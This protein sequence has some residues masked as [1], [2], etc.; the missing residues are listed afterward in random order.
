MAKAKVKA[1]TKAKKTPAKQT[2]MQKAEKVMMA[3]QK[4]VV[5]AWTKQVTVAKKLV[6]KT[7]TDVKKVQEKEKRD[8]LNSPLI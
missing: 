4:A 1:K 5:D 6:A 3:A 7:T 2:A 8:D